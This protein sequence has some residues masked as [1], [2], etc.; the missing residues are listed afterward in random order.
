MNTVTD[1]DI[2]L[3]VPHPCLAT[4]GNGNSI[5]AEL[6]E[7]TITI[8]TTFVSG[9]FRHI[10]SYGGFFFTLQD[11]HNIRTLYLIISN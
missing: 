9:L 1:Q 5:K 6:I 4:V 2:V 3:L 11:K 10:S 8:R 7:E